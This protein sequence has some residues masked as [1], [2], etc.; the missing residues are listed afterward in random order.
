M[1]LNLENEKYNIS[2]LTISKKNGMSL[3]TF[4]NEGFDML[5][6]AIVFLILGL[7]IMF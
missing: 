2:K 6:V 4:L 7:M 1:K 5:G 3:Y